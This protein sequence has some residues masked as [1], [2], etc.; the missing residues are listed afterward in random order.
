MSFLDRFSGLKTIFG[1]SRDFNVDDNL[2]RF[3]GKNVATQSY[4]EILDLTKR[5][6]KDTIDISDQIIEKYSKTTKDDV[7]AELMKKYLKLSQDDLNKEAIAREKLEMQTMEEEVD[8]SIEGVDKNTKEQVKKDLKEQAKEDKEK[9][10]EPTSP[11]DK[12]KELQTKIYEATYNKM[13]KD[14]AYRVMKIKNAQY[15][16]MA[17][18]L[19]TKEAMEII[20]MEKNLEKIDL[21]YHN[22][23]GKDISSVKRIKDEKTKFKSEFNYNQKGIENNTQE[24]AR[25]INLLYVIRAEKY[26]KYIRAL[27]DQSK[28]PQEKYLFKQEY[29]K[30]NLNLL[31]N[32]PSINEYTKDIEVQ[33][34]NEEMADKENLSKKTA[35]NNR[36]DN[37]NGKVEKVSTSK[38]AD[39]VYDIKDTEEKRDANVLDKS[40]KIQ[41]DELNKGNYAVAKQIGDAQRDKR[42]YDDNIKKE[43]VQSTIS[44]TKKEID[45]EEGRSDSDFFNSLRKVNSIEDKTPEELQNIVEDNNK[46]AQDKIKERQYNEQIQQ[47]IQEEKERARNN[48]NKRPNG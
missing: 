7:Q 34:V 5:K 16:S 45:K 10:K 40:M 48:K 18:G 38:T 33:Q 41:D 21:L 6:F 11:K 43:P 46:I 30:A 24:R 2:A 42:V 17:I 37:P 35:I 25:K 47:K 22:H 23:S 27:K 9:G 19:E 26:E 39:L 31:Q 20:A 29:E 44:Q 14:Y 4:D 12:K 3:Y 13:Y 1:K 15:A 36:I 8:S 28:T 32:I